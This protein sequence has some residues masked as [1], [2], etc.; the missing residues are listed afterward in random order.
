[1]ASSEGVA[2]A[3][4]ALAREMPPEAHAVIS[5][6]SARLAGAQGAPAAGAPTGG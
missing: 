4:A 1:M 6:L 3:L 5:R 2:G